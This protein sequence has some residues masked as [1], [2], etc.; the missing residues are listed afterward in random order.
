[1]HFHYRVRRTESGAQELIRKFRPSA[2]SLNIL[3]DLTCVSRPICISLERRSIYRKIE[4]NRFLQPREEL[5]ADCSCTEHASNPYVNVIRIQIVSSNAICQVDAVCH[6]R[7]SAPFVR[8]GRTNCF[9]NGD[10]NSSL[11]LLRGLIEK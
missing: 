7:A 4:N 3:I 8:V 11:Y 10:E 9:D 5:I 1:M 6:A 2:D